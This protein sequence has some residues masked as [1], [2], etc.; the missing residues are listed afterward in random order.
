MGRRKTGTARDGDVW[1]ERGVQ[2][3]DGGVTVEYTIGG[4]DSETTVRVREP[5][6]EGVTL[7]EVGFHPEHEPSEWTLE[8]GSLS[9]E[10]TVPAGGSFETVFGAVADE[11]FLAG[12]PELERLDGSSGGV[13]ASVRGIFGGSSNPEPDEKTTTEPDAEAA[14]GAGTG[15]TVDDESATTDD[16][17][18]DV[19]TADS[20]DGVDITEDN[21][22]ETGG[23]VEPMVPDAEAEPNDVEATDGEAGDVSTDESDEPVD[24]HEPDGSTG[25]HSGNGDDTEPSDADSPDDEA[26]EPTTAADPTETAA[27]LVELV[28][29]DEALRESLREALETEND[30]PSESVDTRLRHVQSRVDDLAAYTAA[31]E[32]S[33]DEHGRPAEAF[34]ELQTETAA[35]RE[36]VADVREEVEEVRTEQ[37][38]VSERVDDLA[39]ETQSLRT[40]LVE[41]GEQR[42]ARLDRL[43]SDVDGVATD[44]RH[45]RDGMES[46][47]D[48]VREEV[49][50]LQS[51]RES[52]SEAFG[53]LGETS[54]AETE[55]A[56][57]EREA[58]SESEQPE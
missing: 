29:E 30:E 16:T 52:L 41:A 43:E 51:M 36:D 8:E 13:L 58:E 11:P 4:T 40:E 37:E 24:S 14:S 21:T 35:L 31:F 48:T 1:L 53:G 10:T 34:D 28:E 45:A 3:K 6:D 7:T 2:R 55:A 20:P 25:A 26:D 50:E 33:I 12:D 17:P 27:A 49:A 15:G 19:E 47:L 46:E 23:E 42:E 39:A 5:I 56:E 44:L 54:G 57:A 18:D 9:F 38:E 32:E 22:D